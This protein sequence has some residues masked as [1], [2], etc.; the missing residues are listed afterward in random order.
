MARHRSESEGGRSHRGCDGLPFMG[1]GTQEEKQVDRA[2]RDV[3]TRVLPRDKTSKM[4]V[5]RCMCM[6]IYTHIHTHTHTHT[7]I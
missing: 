2:K 7:H 5:H 3:S 1:Q 4:C 6:Y